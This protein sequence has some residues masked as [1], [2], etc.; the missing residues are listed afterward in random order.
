MKPFGTQLHICCNTSERA[1]GASA[2]YRADYVVDGVE[3]LLIMAKSR[4]ATLKQLSISRLELQAALMEARLAILVL[5]YIKVEGEVFFCSDSQTTL[6]W[7]RVNDMI[8]LLFVAHRRTEILDSTQQKS[9]RHI[10]GELNPAD[11]LTSGIMAEH[12][13]S[14]HRWF[15]GATFMQFSSRNV[16]ASAQ[17]SIAEE[18]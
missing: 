15:N 13:L 6:Q 8:I 10:P 7:L 16:A 2:Y 12:L 14:S 18:R 4:F 9:W 17:G 5:K 11:D 3:C 1:F